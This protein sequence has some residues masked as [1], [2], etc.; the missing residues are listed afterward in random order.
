MKT[1]SLVNEDQIEEEGEDEDAR[2]DGSAT[3]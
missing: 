2:Q 3:S 1:L